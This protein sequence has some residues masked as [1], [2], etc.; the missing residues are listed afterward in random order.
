[1]LVPL[2][3]LRELID[4]DIPTVELAERLEPCRA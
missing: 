1:M 2:S 3:W 4:V